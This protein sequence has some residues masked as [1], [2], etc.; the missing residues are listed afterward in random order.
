MIFDFSRLARHVVRTFAE[1][2]RPGVFEGDQCAEPHGHVPDT[3]GPAK[4]EGVDLDLVA[5]D[6]SKDKLYWLPADGKR[7][8][9]FGRKDWDSRKAGQVGL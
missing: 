7:Y 4:R 1:V 9:P 3:E 6:G 5:Q 2:R 8:I